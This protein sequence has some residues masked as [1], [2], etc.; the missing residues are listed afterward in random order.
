MAGGG[1]MDKA[2]RVEWTERVLDYL[3]HEKRRCTYGALGGLLGVHPRGVEKYLGDPRPRASWVVLRNTGKPGGNYAPDQMAEG[4]CNGPEPITCPGELW[5]R[6]D[7]DGVLPHPV[8][9][10]VFRWSRW[11]AFPD[12]G[13]GGILTAPFGPGVY[14]LRNRETGERVLFGRSGNV[15]HRMS[16]LLPRPLG[17]GTRNNM[18]KRAYV[19][20]H[21]GCIDYR[22]KPCADNATAVRE[23]GQLRA[24]RHGYLFP[25]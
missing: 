11:Q 14:E 16:S 21:L 10:P 9:I 6:V 24:N 18:G 13:S 20:D 19:R 15:A 12:P 22:T 5:R 7:P 25:T 17:T 4:L 3:N 2:E 23:E 8:G 1:V